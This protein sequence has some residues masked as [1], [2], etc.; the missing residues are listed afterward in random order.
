MAEDAFS[1]RAEEVAQALEG[2]PATKASPEAEDAASAASAM[3]GESPQAQETS[4]APAMRQSMG[5][6]KWN[7]D[8][9]YIDHRTAD[10]DRLEPRRSV[11][12][13]GKDA[14]IPTGSTRD[15]DGKWKVSTS[16][17]DYRTQDV[18]R[19]EPRRSSTMDFK[20]VNFTAAG[21]GSF[22]AGEVS[23]KS[24][25]SAK[26]E[27][28]KWQ[29]VD[30]SYI[31]HRTKDVNRLESRRSLT[32]EFKDTTYTAAGAGSFIAGEVSA[33][34][35]TSAK[36]VD[37]KWQTVDATYINHRTKDVE[38]LEGRKSVAKPSDSVVES[39]TGKVVTSATV[40]KTGGGWKVDVSYVQNRT[41]DTD[42]L[43][44]KLEKADEPKYSSPVETKY[45]YAVLRTSNTERPIDVDPT[46]KDQYLTDE[47]FHTVFA[48]SP[49]DFAKMPK[50]KRDGLKKAKELF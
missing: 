6:G 29:T 15:E 43:E 27:D 4:E 38:R 13:D 32:G 20:D 49:A 5:G 22:I 3:G 7:V 16:Y 41:S 21:T 33:T 8:V 46:L 48:M 34:A 47:E 37:G 2:V 36:T 30:D 25:T 17:I 10:P 45:S 50:W 26:T 14:S 31:N 24:R 11:D 42:N 1:T 35:R 40:N 9:S 19:L 18:D 23:A 44:R 39:S 28:G 12:G